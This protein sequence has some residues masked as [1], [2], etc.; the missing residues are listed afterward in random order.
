M[1]HTSHFT[2]EGVDYTVIHNGDWS[3][4]A[5]ISRRSPDGKSNILTE[6]PGRLL[7]AIGRQATLEEVVATVEDL[8]GKPPR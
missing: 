3:G 1:S 7:I 4:M 5:T 6:I 8:M 2:V